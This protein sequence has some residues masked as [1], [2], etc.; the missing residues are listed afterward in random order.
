MEPV[1]AIVPVNLTEQLPAESRQV[2]ALSEPPVVPALNVKVTVPVGVLVDVV[3]SV[4]VAVTGALQ[5]LAPSAM[6]QLTF[7]TLVEVL[8]LLVAVTVTVAAKLVLVLCVESPPYMAVTDPVP[9]VVPVKVTEQLV[10]PDTVVRVQLLALREPPVVPAVKT[11][12]TVPPGAFEVVVVSTTV[13]ETL[14]VQLVAPRAMLQLTVPILVDV[15]SF[16]TVIVLDVP[17]GLAL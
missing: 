4:T 1:P 17:G 2:L 14:D 13:A 6:L 11:K 7:P 15:L 10:T 12:F 9:T 16:A 3:V 5:L 8:S